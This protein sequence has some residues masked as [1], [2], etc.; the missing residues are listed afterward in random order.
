MAKPVKKRPVG[1]PRKTKSASTS[2]DKGNAG[3]KGPE[4][5]A[6]DGP[7][8]PSAKDNEA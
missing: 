5:G 6:N 4:E 3:A 1:R 7:D 8:G 2:Q